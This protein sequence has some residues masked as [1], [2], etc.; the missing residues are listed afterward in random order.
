MIFPSQSCKLNLFNYL[1][2]FGGEGKA[3]RVW[4][5]DQGDGKDLNARF[6]RNELSYDNSIGKGA[7]TVV[8]TASHLSPL[9]ESTHLFGEGG[10]A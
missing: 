8:V 7:A 2:C 3:F 4:V 6:G 1:F 9:P 5:S 10:D